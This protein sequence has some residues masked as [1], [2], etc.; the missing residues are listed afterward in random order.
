MKKSFLNLVILVLLLLGCDQA[1]IDYA[2]PI[3]SDTECT[4]DAH[5]VKAGCSGQL[6][7]PTEKAKEILTT[8]EIK[9]EYECLRLTQCSCI[10]GKCSWK[11][12]D[13]YEQCIA[14][15]EDSQGPVIV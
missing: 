15:K 12:S 13:E 2:T 1:E 8:C 11:E 6:C 7:L 10:Q 14:E 4:T 5:C 9:P 3:P